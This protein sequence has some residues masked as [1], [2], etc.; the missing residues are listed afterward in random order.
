ME[1]LPKARPSAGSE[2]KG[3]CPECD[4]AEFYV[5]KESGRFYCFKCRFGGRNIVALVA[6]LEDFEYWEAAQWIF[7]RAVPLRRTIP[8]AKL[9]ERIRSM[10]T[11]T[12]AEGE[13]EKVEEELP[14]GF[15]PCYADGKWSLPEYLKKRRIRS[16]TARAWG[17]GYCSGGRFGGRLVIPI[18]CPVGQSFTARDMTETSSIRYLN[19]SEV[20][21]RRLL[22]GWN[23]AR[24]TGDLVICEGPLDAV[25]LWQHGISAV[26]LGGKVLHDEQLAM[27]VELPSDAA[28]T[29][30]L[31]PEARDDA[32]GVAKRLSAHFKHVYLGQLPSGVDPGS[33]TA[34]QAYSALGGAA[35]WKG[36]ALVALSRLA[37]SR[38]AIISKHLRKRATT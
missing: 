17:L 10:R 32:M 24:L 15:K 4:K 28:V 25:K 16:S 14:D 36:G 29:V 5:N 7:K 19:P 22:I 30:M 2:V 21:H 12:E 26:A 13:L 23:M 27:L 37:K 3:I 9:S 34:S 35:P 20:D 8:L 33:S 1:N 18:R 38:A 31:D 11:G 6:K